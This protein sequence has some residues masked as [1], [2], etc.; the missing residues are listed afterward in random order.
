MMDGDWDHGVTTL[1]EF[2]LIA[3]LASRL[4]APPDGI[5]IG[6]DA[7]TW[8]PTPGTVAV[9]TTDVL[10]EGIHFRLDW[11]TP[12]DLGWKALAV[13]LSDV[14]AMGGRPRH[15][16]V[17]LAMAP[18][19]FE[20]ALAIYDGLGACARA[21]GTYVV[22][23]DTVRTTGPL[24]L[25][26]AVYGEAHPD[27]LLRRGGARPGDLLCVTGTVGTS[28]AGLHLLLGEATVD[29][30]TAAPLLAA[31]H[32]P[33]ARLHAGPTLAALGVRGGIDV[34]DGVASEAGH[35]AR[36]S[37]VAIVVDVAALP[38][39]PM[40]VAAFGVD[41]ARHLALTGGEDYELL[42]TLPPELF[43]VA[44]ESVAS[45]TTLT[46]IGRVGEAVPG[47]AVSFESGGVQ[48]APPGKGYVAF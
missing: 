17:S 45:E 16:L 38:V 2:E 19:R 44:R 23:G 40:A 42:V 12:R 20:T 10:V 29:D 13:N 30:E 3:A 11:T 34:S 22:G 1:G 28:A 14:A 27:R 46:V 43:D 37:G 26:V 41:R 33:Q 24:V 9:A 39:H 5:G 36:A 31:H 6:D 18:D 35:L 4:D 47:G 48:V 7:A 15:A 25:N 8:H 21:S 32:R